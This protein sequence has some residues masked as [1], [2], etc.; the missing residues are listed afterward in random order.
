[1]TDRVI[2]IF[3]SST[4]GN[5]A[6]ERLL[7]AE[8]VYPEL[9]ALCREKGFSF[10][11]IDLRWGISKEVSE[12]NRVAQACFDEIARCQAMSPHINFLIMAGSR[13]GWKPLPSAISKE[14]WAV[15]TAGLDSDS[16]F[17]R[18]LTAYYE[19]DEND[20]RQPAYYLTARDEKR[21]NVKSNDEWLRQLLYTVAKTRLP[22][23]C[24]EFNL[25]A[26]EMEIC[27]GYF[28]QDESNR[29]NTFLLLKE[30]FGNEQKR[31]YVPEPSEKAAQAVDLF[32]RLEKSA[33]AGQN[34]CVYKAGDTQYLDRTRI[35][36]EKSIREIIASAPAQNSLDR[37]LSVLT[38]EC[39]DVANRFI[40]LSWHDR[41]KEACRHACGKCLLLT[42]ASGSGKSFFLKY[43]AGEFLQADAVVA[44]LFTDL[45][46]FRRSPYSGLSFLVK[47]LQRQN[48]LPTNLEDMDLQHPILWFEHQ[49]R[50]LSR[51]RQVYLI[52]DT[53]EDS[54]LEFENS[55]LQIALPENA[56]LIATTPT[57]ETLRKT[58]DLCPKEPERIEVLPLSEG[59]AKQL[60]EK[61]LEKR[62]RKLTPAQWDDAAEYLSPDDS[63]MTPLY[64][65]LLAQKLSRVHSESKELQNAKRL[66]LSAL[67]REVVLLESKKK[68]E[69]HQFRLHA[70]GFLALSQAGLSESEL[71]SLLSMDKDV[72]EEIRSQ[73]K[74]TFHTPLDGYGSQCDSNYSGK[75]PMVI[76]AM[77]YSEIHPLLMEIESSEEQLLQLRHGKLNREIRK[78]LQQKGL[79]QKLLQIMRA[80]F[81]Q[82]KWYLQT[83]D[84]I[85]GNLRKVTELLPIC[86]AQQDMAQIHSCLQ[87]LICVDAYIRCGKR[88]EILKYLSQYAATPLEF[89]LLRMLQLKDMLYHIWPDSFLPSALADLQSVE[90]SETEDINPDVFLKA[91]GF[92]YRL[93]QSAKMLRIGENYSSSGIFFP[94]LEGASEFA[95]HNNGLVAVR[96]NELL[97]LIDMDRRR[98]VILQAFA[99]VPPE[100]CYLYW[101]G[102]ELVLRYKHSRLFYRFEDAQLHRSGEERG[103]ASWDGLISREL[104][105]VKAAGGIRE[106][107]VFES[108]AS[109]KIV[110]YWNGEQ[111]ENAMLFYQNDAPSEKLE[112]KVRLHNGLCVVVINAELLEVLDLERER[113]VCRRHFP[114]IT[115][116]E[117]SEDGKMLLVVQRGNT[118]QLLP[119]DG[120]RTIGTM[121]RPKDSFM[122]YQ[123]KSFLPFL[124]EIGDTFTSFFGQRRDAVE[125]NETA[126]S[127]AP[128]FCAMSIRYNFLACYYRIRSENKLFLFRLDDLSPMKKPGKEERTEAI[129]LQ[130]ADRIPLYA[131]KDRNAVIICTGGRA[132]LLDMDQ[133]KWLTPPESAIRKD[134]EPGSAEAFILNRYLLSL[135]NKWIA[136]HVPIANRRAQSPLQKLLPQRR[137]QKNRSR[138]RICRRDTWRYCAVK[139]SAG[140]LTGCAA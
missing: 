113:V 68:K 118:L 50:Q 49:L 79:E 140:L 70:F 74:G 139:T 41:A 124:Y 36:L 73:T 63:E 95:L 33:A 16:I 37:E 4:F 13:Y 72:V 29:R 100:E 136:Y 107:E 120:T 94:Q 12:E 97:R 138:S 89:F 69:Y 51:V 67:I 56:A 78:L 23:R 38:S 91:G 53:L 18:L 103:C 102:N 133:K 22:A 46:P 134:P 25:S 75:V 93:L 6:N 114:M 5:F 30:E 59:E 45:M 44:A 2:R 34:L 110:T 112:L 99:V 24:E 7:L 40:P 129:T 104:K 108:T 20:V 31:S 9:D 85:H 83:E 84:G 125:R 42:G 17:M 10:Q 128:L 47:E 26:T 101:K 80:Y 8:E 137:V 11:V 117:W 82:T 14:D 57:I 88:Y 58:V 39:R 111:F 19:L 60:V 66:S 122:K 130:D 43:L 92:S 127:K 21:G 15:L 61:M 132:H 106:R 119:I 90:L 121:Q 54:W 64:L 55:I 98:G 86:A 81:I 116:V 126:L 77:L 48:A 27:R 3:V 135:K 123:T 115:N 71:L 76:W 109:T 65:E 62:G 131:A 32:H 96:Q 87:D 28:S 1:M 52:I 35:F 105:K